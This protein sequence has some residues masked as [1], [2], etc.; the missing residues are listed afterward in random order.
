MNTAKSTEKTTTTNTA[1]MTT[2][3]VTSADGTPIGYLRAGQGPAVVVLHGSNES[4][5]S[6]TH[7][8]LALASKFTVYL[9]DRRGRGLSGS[10]KADHGMRTE[11]EDLRAV[12]AESGA[13]KVFGVSVS[14]LI[15]GRPHHPGHPPGRRL[16][17]GP[18][19]GHLRQLHRVGAP[20]RPGDGPRPGGATIRG[21]AAAAQPGVDPGQRHL[22]AQC[23][24]RRFHPQGTFR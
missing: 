17:A 23:R 20:L 2:G 24:H 12:V 21:R 9:P 6:H 16:R 14:A 18:A 19:D 8:A 22:R 1:G 11:V 3:L 7:L 4:A 10:H 13:Q 5:R 15:A